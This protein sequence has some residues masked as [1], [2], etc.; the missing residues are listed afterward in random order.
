M[1]IYKLI[2]LQGSLLTLAVWASNL[3]SQAA[4]A[5]FT[6]QVSH[7]IKLPP[8]QFSVI[9]GLVLS[10]GWLIIPRPDRKNVRL[11]FYRV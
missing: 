5:W 6:K 8:Y 2:L 1:T 3:T 9:V 10:D 11:G 7:M 4:T